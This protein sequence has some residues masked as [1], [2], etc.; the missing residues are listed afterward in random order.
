VLWLL[1]PIAITAVSTATVKPLLEPRFL[2]VVV[3]AMALVAA[4]GICRLP[5]RH[6]GAL[7]VVLLLVSAVGL[8]QWYL[9]PAQE[10]W[11]GAAA[12]VAAEV[13]PGTALV[14]QPWGGVFS[15]RYYEERLVATPLLRPEAG[16]PPAGR[17]LVEVTRRPLGGGRPPS[18]PS[19][20]AWRDRHYVLRDEETRRRVAVRTYERVPSAEVGS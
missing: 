13:D 14:V 16:D 11:E 18:D 10:D 7:L 8:R 9:E 19:Y 17:E 15:L 5:L 3:P 6:G 1:L 2:I 20:L 4:V 12:L